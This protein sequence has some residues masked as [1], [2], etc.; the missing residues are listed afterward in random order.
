[1]DMAMVSVSGFEQAEADP[2]MMKERE[3]SSVV[4]RPGRRTKSQNIGL[5]QVGFGK[6][7]H[8][9]LVLVC[10]ESQ[11]RGTG[12]GWGEIGFESFEGRQSDEELIRVAL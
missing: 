11:K 12:I 7:A 10:F 9:Y 3:W 6:S 2:P 8:M 5:I 1:M 4:C